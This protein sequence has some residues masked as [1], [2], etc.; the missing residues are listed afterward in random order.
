MRLAGIPTGALLL[1]ALPLAPLAAQRP[2]ASRALRVQRVEIMD[3]QGFEKPLVAATALVPVGWKPVGEVK[4]DPRDACGPGYR[5]DW[6][7]TSPDG[8]G[9]MHLLANEKWSS[10]GPP[11]TQ[12]PCLVSPAADTRQYLEWLVRRVRPGAR[13]LDY[14]ARPELVQ[15]FQSLG[16]DLRQPDGSGMRSWVEA[17]EILIGYSI[18]GK[19]VREAI[20]AS[21]F[22]IHSTFPSLMPGPAPQLLQG[23]TLLVFAMRAPDGALDFKTADALRQSIQSAP[24]WSARMRRSAEE[25]GRVQSEANRRMA[26]DN[27]R[28]AAERSA[29]I[30]QTGRE[31]SEMQMGTWQRQNEGMDR[32]QRERVEAIRGVETYDDPHFGGT[33]QLSSQYGNAWQ[34]RDGSYVLTD[35]VNFDPARDLGVQ[36]Q[37]LKRTQ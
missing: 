14:R 28:G 25:R 17:G 22:F 23:S 35:D 26:E 3:R 19:P 27:R 8:L 11:G 21:L 30:A 10:G 7:A 12:D 20:A 6:E 31:V 1:A 24:E 34:L 15:G 13:V 2:A 9:A 29:I 4:W 5:I 37:R 16:S 32:Q 36:G 33:V 18:R